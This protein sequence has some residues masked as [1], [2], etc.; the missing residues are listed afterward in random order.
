[1]SKLRFKDVN[2]IA[3]GFVSYISKL[4]SKKW[5]PT[6][7]FLPGEFH[8]QRSMADYSPWRHKESDTI[9]QLTLSLSLY[10][11]VLIG[12]FLYFLVLCWNSHLHIYHFSKSLNILIAISFNFLSSK[13]FI[14]LSLGFFRVFFLLFH[15]KHMLISSRFVYLSLSLWS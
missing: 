4:W 13:L 11:S 8:G 15:L 10:S 5:Q 3:Y 2:K 9:E 12:S 1:M 6:P 7:V 14:S